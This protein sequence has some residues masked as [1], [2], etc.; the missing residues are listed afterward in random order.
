[1]RLNLD[2]MQRCLRGK[3]YVAGA[4]GVSSADP[5]AQCANKYRLYLHEGNWYSYDQKRPG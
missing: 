3:E 1:M 5:Q 2:N 4:T